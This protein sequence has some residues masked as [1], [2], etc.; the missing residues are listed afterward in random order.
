MLSR[1]SRTSRNVYMPRVE[2]E[3]SL[4]S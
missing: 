3:E 2:N 1:I 4:V